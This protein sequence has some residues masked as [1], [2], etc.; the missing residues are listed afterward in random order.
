MSAFIPITGREKKTSSYLYLVLDE[1]INS[2]NVL[3]HRVT[4]SDMENLG[5]TC[6]QE[7]ESY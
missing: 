5:S 7:K 6:K 1:L 4:E 3:I 2:R